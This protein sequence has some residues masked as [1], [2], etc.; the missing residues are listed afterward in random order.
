VHKHRPDP[1]ALAMS[2]S[3]PPIALRWRVSLI[4]LPEA[5]STSSSHSDRKLIASEGTA[6]PEPTAP[7]L[8]SKTPHP[9]EIA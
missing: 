9:S 7:A 8:Q 2:P 1:L 5:Q 3:F 4:I 6:A